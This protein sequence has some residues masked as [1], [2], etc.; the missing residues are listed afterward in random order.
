VRQKPAFDRKAGFSSKGGS[1]WK[2]QRSFTRSIPAGGL[3]LV[4]R[5]CEADVWPEEVP[6]S[7]AELLER[8]R[9]IEGLLSLLTD[10][11]D[12]GLVDAR[13]RAGDEPL[14]RPAFSGYAG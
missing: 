3:D 10:P 14:V 2:S 1:P 6:P 4:R 12:A 7:R 13:V 11:V 5:A 9:G 8:V